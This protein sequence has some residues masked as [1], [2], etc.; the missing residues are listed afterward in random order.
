[1]RCVKRSPAWATTRD[2]RAT[3]VEP[4]LIPVGGQDI[5][6]P[7]EFGDNLTRDHCRAAVLEGMTIERMADA[8][9]RVYEAALEGGG[10]AS[11]NGSL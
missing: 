9:L 6:G 2:R 3:L 10:E 7:Q 5:P 11:A 8:M 1:M 4:R